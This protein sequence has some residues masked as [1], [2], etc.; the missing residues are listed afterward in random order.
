MEKLDGFGRRPAPVLV[1][2]A[3]FQENI[4]L[5]AIV[6]LCFIFPVLSDTSAEVFIVRIGKRVGQVMD[7]LSKAVIFPYAPIL[8]FLQRI[9]NMAYTCC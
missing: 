2:N 6:Q 4:S 5:E 7:Q 1:R 9:N 8:V 3:L